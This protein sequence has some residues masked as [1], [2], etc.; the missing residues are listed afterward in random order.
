M[1]GGTVWTVPHAG[2]LL[3]THQALDLG[4]LG[5]ALLEYRGATDQD[6]EAK[7][8]AN[9]HLISEAP[10]V[11]VQ[12]CDLLGQHVTSAAQLG[13]PLALLRCGR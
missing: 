8:V 12:L 7:V 5:V 4:Q 10:Q 3:Q 13:A 6:V 2:A 9:C 1:R 11:P